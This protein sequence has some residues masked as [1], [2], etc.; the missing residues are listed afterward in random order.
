MLGRPVVAAFVA[1][2]VAAAIGAGNFFIVR[3]LGVEP[4][5]RPEL[6]AWLL[7]APLVFVALVAAAASR[8]P[9]AA[10]PEPAAAKA[11]EGEPA[12]DG[13]LRLLGILQEEG[14]LVDFLSESIDGYPDD[15]IGAAVRGIHAACRQALRDRVEL[16]PV[17]SGA[18]GD[19][20]TVP[21]GFDPATIRLS[22]N[23]AGTPPFRGVLRHAGWRVR[24][25]TLPARKGHDPLVVAPAEVEIG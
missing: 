17:L 15:Q 14:R 4:L 7:G 3:A 25:V 20:V 2:V 8:A 13:A 12:R 9:A 21:A 1:L 5:A 16:E 18:E 24:T 11:P 22:G 6:A 23:V 19:V 10:P